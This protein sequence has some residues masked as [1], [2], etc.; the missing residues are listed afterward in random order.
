VNEHEDV[1]FLLLQVK[2]HVYVFF[3]LC[4]YTRASQDPDNQD[5]EQLVLIPIYRDSAQPGTSRLSG[6]RRCIYYRAWVKKDIHV[7]L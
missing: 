6:S 5:V 3:Y 2:E 4:P 1:F 7:L